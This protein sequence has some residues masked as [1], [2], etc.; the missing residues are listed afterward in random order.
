L[1]VFF[2]Q[3]AILFVACGLFARCLLFLKGMFIKMKLKRL[4]GIKKYQN[5]KNVVNCLYVFFSFIEV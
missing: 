3:Q 5:F 1:L 4:K 2:K